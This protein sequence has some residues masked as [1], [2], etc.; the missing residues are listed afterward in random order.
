MI[1]PTNRLQDVYTGVCALV[2]K[3]VEADAAKGVPEAAALVRV[4]TGAPG[5]QLRG[6]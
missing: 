2:R 6:A 3:R 4:T 5:V 1:T